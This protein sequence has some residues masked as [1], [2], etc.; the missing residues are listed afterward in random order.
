MSDVAAQMAPSSLNIYAPSVSDARAKFR[1]GRDLGGR[2]KTQRHFVQVA[3]ELGLSVCSS[4]SALRCYVT[5]QQVEEVA[6]IEMKKKK[7]QPLRTRSISK[8][9]QGS[10]M[11]KRCRGGAGGRRDA[12]EWAE[13]VGWIRTL[14][15]D[16]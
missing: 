13:G 4:G 10:D 1:R 7:V 9:H 5:I 15:P 6:A 3:G 12:H 2:A 11:N 8:H 16:R 14:N